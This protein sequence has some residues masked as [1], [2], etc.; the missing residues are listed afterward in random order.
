MEVIDETSVEI[1][2]NQLQQQEQQQQLQ[3]Y[4][5]GQQFIQH[6]QPCF[7]PSFGAD[8][9]RRCS[10]ISPAAER[11]LVRQ[12]G[13]GHAP[14]TAAADVTSSATYGEMSG[15]SG[16]RRASSYSSPSCR[17]LTAS[18]RIAPRCSPKPS[19][20]RLDATVSASCV[21]SAP[22]STSRSLLN[23]KRSLSQRTSSRRYV[24]IV[25][26]LSKNKQEEARVYL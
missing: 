25:G 11:H 3:H 23:V 19:H 9:K 16:R 22:S 6:K 20:T 7:D 8:T 14:L 17:S 12:P 21:T 2:T 5:S 4:K 26:C 18:P 1:K 15:K 13:G 10:R 24:F